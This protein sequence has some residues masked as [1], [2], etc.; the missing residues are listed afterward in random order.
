M[1]YWQHVMEFFWREESLLLL[2]FALLLG[3]VLLRFLR[4]SRSSVT[5]TLLFF[6][7]CWAIQ[8]LSSLVHALEFTLIANVFY[9][10]GLIGTG[11]ALIRLFGLLLFRIVLPRMRVN[12]PRIAED[13]FVILCY[14]VWF[15]VRLSHA[16]L[17]LGSI[18]ATSAVITAVIAFAMQDTL[19]NI[20]GG[21]ALQLD[22]SIEIGDWIKV[23]DISG[24]VVDIRWR[25]TL[26]E[27][28]NWETV[29]FPNSQLMKNKFLV[30]GR[31]AD[32]PVQWRRW[33]WFNTD[34]EVSPAK[35]IG[36]VETA[37]SR[38]EIAHVAQQPAP[39][40][41]LMEIDRGCAR[42]ALRYWLTDLAVD[43]PTDS[44]MRRHLHA[45][46]ARADIRLT[47]EEQSVHYVK[48]NEKRAEAL[49]QRELALRHK[50]LRRIALFAQLTDAELQTLAEHLKYV[51][52]VSGDVIARQGEA[53]EHWLFI[54]IR[55]EAEVFLPDLRAGRRVLNV[56][57]EGDFF[58]EM[59]LLTGSPRVAS[60]IARTDLE[61]YRLDKESF[62]EILRARPAIAEEVTNVLMVRQEELD[63]ALNSMG[64]A[65]LVQEQHPPRTE[66]L[67]IVKRFFGL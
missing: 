46:L 51:S 15:L 61:C 19:G 55:G 63:A 31:R 39:N 38:A 47:V 27:T 50:T 57:T 3:A 30:L 53:S 7:A 17:D 37:L 54:I 42:Y 26:V 21:L 2:V 23:D 29:V 5:N 60:V 49:H 58:G 13:F 10:I 64:Q 67:A 32:Q 11:V 56:L 16:G 14:V 45:A 36:A 9:E 34:L 33:I 44:A 22:N 62:E 35:V 18:L 43:D 40:C 52:Y 8:F 25:S 41:V 66:V 6:L 65:D 59:S 4:E 1:V 48:Y 28:R 24:R 20:L 12:P